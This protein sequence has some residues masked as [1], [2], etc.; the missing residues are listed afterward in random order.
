[1]LS[2]NNSY[3][4][5]ELR[6][7]GHYFVTGYT[8]DQFCNDSLNITD[9]L[10][11]LHRYL[12]YEEKF[13]A[14]FFM[15]MRRMVFCLDQSSFDILTGRRTAASPSPVQATETGE[16][17]IIA[18][19]PVGHRVRR[20]RRRVVQASQNGEEGN[21]ENH[22]QTGALNLG[23]RTV[24]SAWEQVTSV[25]RNSGFQCALV[26]SIANTMSYND[27]FLL[28]LS[29]LYTTN[30]CVVIYVFRESSSSNFAQWRRLSASSLVALED[31]TDPYANRVISLRTPNCREV[32]DLLNS[33]RLNTN[34]SISILPG[35]IYPLGQILAASCARKKWGLVN[36]LNRLNNH[37]L[38]HPGVV[39]SMESWKEFTEEKNYVSPMEELERMIGQ[40]KLKEK[41]RGWLATQQRLGYDRAEPLSSSRFA[42]LPAQNR[43]LG[44]MLNVRL[45][46]SPGTGKTTIA[47]ILGRFYYDIG[48]L[49][50][51]QFVECSAADLISGYVGHTAEQTHRLVEDA[52]GGV[53]FIDEAYALMSNQHGQEAINQLVNDMSTYEGQLA[54]II[55]GYPRQIDE[56]MR[57]NEGLPRRFP[58]EYIL[59]DYSAQ[60]M[61][62]I[63]FQMAQ[64]DPDDISFSDELMERA[65]DFFEAWVGGAGRNWGNAGEAQNLLIEMKKLSAVRETSQHSGR[66]DIYITTA[67]VPEHLRHCLAKRSQNIDE[68]LDQIDNK[69]IGLSNVKAY[70]RKLVQRVKIGDGEKAPGNF[71][72]Y[73]PPGTGKTTVARRMGELLGLLGV[74]KRRTNNVTE[75]RAADLLNG[76][77]VLEEAVDD[78]RKGVFFLDEAHQ[79]AESERGRAIIRA[80]VPLI[81]DPEIH[82]DTCFILAGYTA[83]MERFLT[84]DD[85]LERRF[86]KQNRI[87]FTDYTPAELVQI[88]EQMATESGQQ[89]TPA[90]LRRSR[91]ALEKFMQKRDKN[92]G[93]G[94]FIRDEFLPESIVTRTARLNRELTGSDRGIPTDEQLATLSEQQ[95]KELTEADIPANME[96]YAGPIGRYYNFNENCAW[97][98]VQQ[99]LEKDAIVSFARSRITDSSEQRFFDSDVVAGLHYAILG[100][101]GCGKHTAVKALAALWRERGLLEQ[102][103]VAFVGKGDLEAGYVGQ[104]AEKTQRL[105]EK[106]VGGTIVIEYPSTLLPKNSSDNT[107][108]PEALGVI[109]SAM[110]THVNDTS[111]VFFDTPEGFEEVVR[112]VPDLR[113]RLAGIFTLEDLSPDVMLQIFQS[114]IIRSMQLEHSL[115]ELMPDFFLNWVSDR[116]GL[117]D[118]VNSWGNGIEVDRLIDSIK[119]NWQ[120]AGG[121]TVP[122]TITENGISYQLTK[123][124]ITSEHIPSSLSRYIRKTDSV[125][126][127]AMQELNALP[128]LLKVKESI[129]GIRRRIRHNGA[130]NTKPGCYLYLGNPGVG[131]T[132]VAKLMGKVLRACGVLKQGHVIVRTARQIGEHFTE[133]DNIVKLAKNGIL[134]IDEAHQLG[135]PRNPYGNEI[136]KRLLTVLEDDSVTNNTCIILAG[137]PVPM[138]RLLQMDDGLSSRFGTQDCRIVFDDYNAD[139]L[140]QIAL[141]MATRANTISAIGSS[142]PLELSEGYI[143]ATR[144]IFSNILARK[145]PN[146]GNARFIRTFL[147]DSLSRQ[148]IRLD[149][150][151]G[152]ENLPPNTA[153]SLLTDEDI[154]EVYRTLTNAVTDRVAIS[155]KNVNT[156][157]LDYFDNSERTDIFNGYENSVVLIS[158]TKDGSEGFGSGFF[159]TQGGL[160]LTCS[161]VVKGAEKIRVRISCPGA[162]GGDTR[163]F[164]GMVMEPICDDCDLAVLRLDGKNFIQAPIRPAGETI[165]TGEHT[166][167]IGYP[168][169]GQLTGGDIDK[170]NVS[171]FFGQISSVQTNNGREL[172]FIDTRGLHGNSGSPV[173]SISDGRVIGVF[174]GSIIPDRQNSLDEI[175][176]FV[177]IR[178]FWERFVTETDQNSCNAAADVQNPTAI[179]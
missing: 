15:D 62:E 71:M 40:E 36:L 129:N 156:A 114:K 47:R 24:N 120:N 150:E 80:L 23:R 56:L 12:I 110:N 164:D 79:L 73:G 52:M 117:S 6:I 155:S 145:N 171:R 67:D 116:G 89:P 78:A 146:F 4:N 107:F 103:Y 48:L 127:D 132:T 113:S 170:L 153:I 141:Y 177:P 25:M 163:W 2:K 51:G 44:H 77:V 53:L 59:E 21:A 167:L 7:R 70:L 98:R 30:H 104:T 109:L 119:L 72:F 81:E 140:I 28:E 96:I 108:G 84:V 60:E 95:R 105:I 157:S 42:P 29:S 87:R 57:T 176:Y 134:F 19:G 138:M 65:D 162:I 149:R 158:V 133:F 88:L 100:P 93:N 144:T 1:M 75:C 139:E 148:L 173:Y 179:S 135:E 168:L 31:T 118:S 54:V 165:E 82:A 85:G 143:R 112:A 92:F 147:H 13:D 27:E 130:A 91:I 43:R 46:G 39:L 9:I 3:F 61:R 115:S 86:P 175:N 137:Y 66:Q 17:E 41:V 111:F 90:Y 58:E 8:N 26:I 169:G 178:Y 35:D 97:E 101:A 69:M 99:L 122:I 50:Q 55:A 126:A 74:L 154:P 161:H 136:I 22:P 159:V 34:Y 131:K 49:P 128:G 33:I 121:Q 172:V 38:S 64:N 14:V 166:V 94:G 45:K 76:S 124:L 20:R 68:A 16:E 174:S 152:E 10:P 102:D 63:F 83:E 160:V 37:A 123:R 106:N 32:R 11:E 125:S 142:V 151:Y 18:S 5:S